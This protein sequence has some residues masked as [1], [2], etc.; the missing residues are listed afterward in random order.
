MR[1]DI[2]TIFPHILDSYFNESILKRAQTS[3]KIA[4]NNHDLRN[5]TSDPHKTVDDSPYGGGPGMVMKVD[6]IYRAVE[7]IKNKAGGKK[8]R[9][10][11]FSAKGK[12]FTQKDAHRYLEYDQLI[13]ICGRY[14]GIDQRVIDHIADEEVSIG[15]YVLT[16]GELPAGVI[17]DS[18]ARLIP[19]VLG[20]EESIVEESYTGE[21]TIEYPQYTR[22]EVYNDWKVPD[23]L[24]TGNHQAIKDWRDQQRKSRAD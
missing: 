18:V 9:V 8:V 17:V 22:P 21:E 20:N 19:G 6:P 12:K 7:D 23:V 1:F 10:I 2:I 16:G 11:V 24:I 3:G 5:W 4:I 14:E 13:L 15:E